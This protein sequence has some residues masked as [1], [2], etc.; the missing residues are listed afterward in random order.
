MNMFALNK[1]GMLDG[2]KNE[3]DTST[4]LH[5]ISLE[6]NRSVLI[7]SDWQYHAMATPELP[8]MV[9]Y[10]VLST[11]NSLVSPMVY[12]Q[13]VRMRSTASLLLMITKMSSKIALLPVNAQSTSGWMKNVVSFR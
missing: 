12:S 4:N 6:Y 9:V 2:I 11:L 7:I 13:S 5:T 1:S 10:L 3:I 8:L